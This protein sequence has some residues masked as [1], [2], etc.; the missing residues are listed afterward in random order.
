[1]TVRSVTRLFDVTLHTAADGGPASERYPQ[2][3]I[4]V[5]ETEE[6]SLVKQINGGSRHVP[7]STLLRAEELDKGTVLNLPL[8]VTNFRYLDCLGSRFNVAR[9]DRARFPDGVCG[10]RGIFDVSRFTHVPPEPVKA[11]FASDDPLSDP[12]VRIEFRW[13]ILQAGT[14]TVNLPVDLPARFGARFNQARFSHTKDAPDAHFNQTQAPELYDGAVIEPEKAVKDLVKFISSQSNF[15]DASIVPGVDLGWTAVELPFRRPQSLTLGRPGQAARLYLKGDGLDGFI[16]LEAKKPGSWGNQIAVAVRRAGPAIYD[17]SVI[18]R[19][20][21][22]ESARAAV[23][24][25]P[26]AELTQ[27]LLKPGPVGVLQAKAAGCKAKVTRDR[28][29]YEELTTTT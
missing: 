17:I 12:P 19:A 11:V 7:G 20:S 2:V 27:G 16:K 1:M 5:G 6:D 14:F 3:T 26:A 21:R 23:L 8:G 24:G 10:E 4:G 15:V 13:R 9:F 18:Y 25:Q 22:F 28:A 29:E